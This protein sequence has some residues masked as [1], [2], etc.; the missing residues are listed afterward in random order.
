MFIKSGQYK[1]NLKMS[2]NSEHLSSVYNSNIRLRSELSEYRRWVSNVINGEIAVLILEML[3][4]NGQRTKV[5]VEGWSGG[6]RES[7][8][9]L[10]RINLIP[11]GGVICFLYQ[12][13]DRCLY[14]KSIYPG[15]KRLIKLG[16]GMDITSFNV[17]FRFR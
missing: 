15:M 10:S 4:K 14:F 1:Y 13:Y 8:D 12:D 6:R 16:Y 9:I 5:D 7:R 17:L 11:L 3:L 2:R